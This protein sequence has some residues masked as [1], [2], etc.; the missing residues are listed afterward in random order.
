MKEINRFLT[1]LMALLLAVGMLAGIVPETTY[2]ASTESISVTGTYNYSMANS[3]LSEV[4][5]QRS[6]NGLSKLTM[7]KTLTNEAMKRAAELSIYFSHTR[8]N[9]SSYMTAYSK[10][11]N[12][13]GENIAAGQSSA[14]AVMSS[15]MNS[16]DHKANILSKNYKSIGIGSFTNN[17]TTY[18]VQVFSG[19]SGTSASNSGSSSK[20]VSVS[21]KSSYISGALT[22][23]PSS[24]SIKKGKT[25]S[26]TAYIKNKGSS[27]FKAKINNSCLKW[28]SGST[29]V[30]TV[31]SSGTVTGKAKGSAK[32]TAKTSGGSASAST[33]ITVTSDGSSTTPVS[34]KVSISKCT[35]SLS[36][37]NY[38]YD[39]TA[40]KPTVTVKYGSKTL[41]NGTDYSV[42]YKDNVNKG[43]AH[44]TITGKG[45]YTGSVTKS[46]IINGIQIPNCKTTL[47]QTSYTYDGN[48]KKPTVTVKNGSKTLKSGTN[49]TVTYKNNTN[50]GTA[51]VTV[52]GTGNYAGSVTKT[53]KINA[54]SI[55]KCTVSLSQT[56]YTYDGN[57]KKPTVTVKNGSKTLK[58]G[59]DYSVT[60]KN[61]TSAGTA[62]AT[63]TGK[64]NYTGSVSKNFTIKKGDSS[65]TTTIS[66]K[67]PAATSITS[68]KSSASGQM[69]VKWNK[70]S[71]VD[72]YALMYSMSP[73]FYAYASYDTKG[74][75]IF[76]G[77]SSTSYTFSNMQKGKTYY[78]RLQTYQT[79]N[80]KKTYSDWSSVKSVVIAK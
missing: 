74:F 24:S 68:L 72:G 66:T 48:A 31:S 28:S 55:S 70:V 5:S 4:N 2:A 13:C 80:G 18:W 47:S 12:S 44:V 71:G 50:A 38:T 57:A 33:T 6:K 56:S 25:T 77:D 51:S 23:T 17:G 79:I 29:S 3:V 9:G 22:L 16:K 21:A 34:T 27:G 64:G 59:T 67:K 54:A 46:F 41:K 35:I 52:A 58:S 76:P 10:L 53:F 39:G 20:T 75:E 14:S 32:I 19:N 1:K 45:N 65:T 62:T 36:K 7:D 60:Y 15:W 42:S 43:T 11:G 78:V 63:I 8:P 26:I 69:S 73:N 61:N 49:Y 30:A 40:K 37:T